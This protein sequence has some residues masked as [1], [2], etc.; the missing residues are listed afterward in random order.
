VAVARILVV[1][2]E[3]GA[4]QAIADMLEDE[5]HEVLVARAGIGAMVDLLDQSYDLLITDIVMP[6]I[7]GWELIKLVRDKRPAT[8][9]IAISGGG[10]LL[11]KEV[12][13]TVSTA[14]GADATLLKPFSAATLVSTVDSVLHRPTQ[15]H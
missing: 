2:D 12:A 5:G 15:A 9:V 3:P 13:A 4:Q 14:L 6:E 10:K 11:R 7:D 8:P 1:D